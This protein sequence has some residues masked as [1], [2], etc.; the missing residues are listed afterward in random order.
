M[1]RSFAEIAER[2]CRV[3]VYS[4]DVLHEFRAGTFLD[5]DAIALDEFPAVRGRCLRHYDRSAQLEFLSCVR[6]GT[7]VVSYA[8]N[9]G[10]ES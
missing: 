9:A 3:K 2:S 5:F 6:E 1:K 10:K 7:A 4:G 8:K